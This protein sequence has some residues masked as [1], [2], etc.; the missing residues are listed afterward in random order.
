MILVIRAK[1]RF[2]SQIS[3]YAPD[4]RI[5]GLF[6]VLRKPANFCHSGHGIATAP[7]KL[8]KQD[9]FGQTCDV[10]EGIGLVPQFLLGIGKTS[11]WVSPCEI[12]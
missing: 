8:N 6:C 9:L 12:L 4:E 3:K 11:E 2:L 7:L 1:H 10:R 5:G